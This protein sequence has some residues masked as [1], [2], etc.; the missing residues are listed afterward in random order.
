MKRVF[1]KSNVA[2]LVTLSSLMLGIQ[3]ADYSCL[4][5][6]YAHY[7]KGWAYLLLV[8]MV[9]V[10]ALNIINI[11]LACKHKKVATLIVCVFIL[12]QN[13]LSHIMRVMIV[14]TSDSYKYNIPMP[15]VIFIL[16]GV[17]IPLSVMYIVCGLWNCNRKSMIREIEMSNEF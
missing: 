1:T 5:P 16:P 13:I 10:T 4:A 12:V 17:S 3:A 6:V 7:S 8:F 14:I 9:P 11:V 2:T 15:I